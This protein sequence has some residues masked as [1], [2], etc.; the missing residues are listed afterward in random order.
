MYL[1]YLF[2]TLSVL[3]Y[4]H[5][6]FSPVDCNII[7]VTEEYLSIFSLVVNCSVDGNA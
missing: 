3:N 5:L 1:T 2:H 7:L 4:A 6:I